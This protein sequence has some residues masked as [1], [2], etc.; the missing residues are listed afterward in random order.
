M[1]K[2]LYFALISVF[3]GLMLWSDQVNA[4][5]NTEPIFDVEY[6]IR[7]EIKE[8]AET[9]VF[10]SVGIINRQTD[11]I[12]TNYTL[13]IN[14]MSVYDAKAFMD[15]DELETKLEQENSTYKIKTKFEQQAIGE[16]KKTQFDIEYKT[17]DIASQVGKIWNINIPKVEMSNNT[18]LY[19]IELLVP[20]S[21]GPMIFVSPT[22]S[23]IEELANLTIFRFSKDQLKNVGISASFGSYQLVNFRLR[24]QLQNPS[25]FSSYYEIALPPDLKQRQ[26]VIFH[27]LKPTPTKMFVDED[28]NFIAR[29]KLKAKEQMDVEFIGAAKIFG[30]QINPTFGGEFEKIPQKIKT[31]YTKPDT[32]WEVESSEIQKIAESLKDKN[33]NVTLNAQKAYE[34]TVAKLQYDFDL[35]NKETVVRKGAKQALNEPVKAACMEFTDLFIAIARAMGIPARE[36]NGYA[37][38]NDI[39]NAPLSVN[40]RG[41]DYL[42]AWPEFYDPIYGW[43]AV[44]P[45]WGNTSKVDYFTK[46]DTNHF[47]FSVKGLDSEFPAPAGSYKYDEKN[48]Q[49]EVDFAQDTLQKTEKYDL[50]LTKL[51]SL[52]PLKMFSKEQLYRV[53]NTGNVTIYNPNNNDSIILP[54][55]S[56]LIYIEN[57]KS[58]ISY[59]DFIGSRYT[60]ALPKSA[61]VQ[62]EAIFNKVNLQT[63][64]GIGGVL[65]LYTILYWFLIRLGI[66]R[67]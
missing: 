64:I 54:N 43:I 65:V 41:G 40:L 22:P 23:D 38:A 59:E 12:P 63:L 1:R 58:Y 33:A 15:G 19:N 62:A 60:A 20:K 37:I 8:T 46:L 42:H 10:Q 11:V 14:Q 29:Y 30:R 49:V 50:R 18:K 67:K 24:Y 13:S 28:G 45:T 21:F 35:G 56:A 17:K 32:Y 36:L 66:R 52:N 9:S 55:G 53:E 4:Q 7:Y 61:P 6:N 2:Y 3:A 47:V 27:Q 5:S 16:G 31:A 51:I 57:S 26:Q 48:K 25:S 34:F 39:S 44:D